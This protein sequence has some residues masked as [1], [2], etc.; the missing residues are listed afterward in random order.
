MNAQ[1]TN[2]NAFRPSV[3][4]ARLEERVALSSTAVTPP[5]APLPVFSRILIGHARPWHT[6]RQLR[7]DYAHQARVAALVLRNE[8]AYRVDQLYVNG[9]VP[10]AQQLAD[11]NASAQGAV[12]GAALRLSSQALSSQVASSTNSAL[13]AAAMELGSSLSLFSGSS[14]VLSQV[15]PIFFSSTSPLANLATSLQSIPSGSQAFNSAVTSAFNTSFSTLLSP[16]TSF[17]GMPS[18]T[19]AT[20]PTSGLTSPFTSQFNASRF[21]SGF[22]NG[23]ASNANTGF[24]GFGVAPTVFNTN[25]STG[26]NTFASMATQSSGLIITPLGTIGDGWLTR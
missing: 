18:Q 20:L 17:L 19:N 5:P 23:F 22:N 15:A 1:F 12:D 13:D 24:V 25:F 3:T 8:I 9:S 4:D 26:F 7:A 14:N 21:D 2:R 10:T 16:L 6:L 11:F